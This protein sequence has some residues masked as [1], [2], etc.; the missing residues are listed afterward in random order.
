MEGARL[1]PFDDGASVP[2]GWLATIVEVVQLV[3]ILRHVFLTNTFSIPFA[4]F[5]PR[6]EAAEAKAINCPVVSNDGRSAREFAAVL[7][8]RVEARIVEGVQ[9]VVVASKQLSR[10]YTSCTPPE[11]KPRFVPIDVNAIKRPFVPETAVCVLAPFAG[12]TPS[13]VD[14]RSVCPVQEVNCVAHVRV[15]TSARP[16]GFGAVAPRFRAVDTNAIRDAAVDIDGAELGPFPG[17]VPSGVET[18]N[19][20]GEHVVVGT[21]PHVTRT[22]T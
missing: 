9:V 3:V 11:L 18:R 14:T 2:A 15:K 17:V 21:P 13:G 1:L 10:I 19:V 16:L 12:V 20:T 6:F 8:S 4:V 5:A 22:K 7:P